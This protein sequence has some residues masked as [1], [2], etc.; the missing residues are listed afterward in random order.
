M[1]LI[2]ANIILEA[3]LQQKKTSEVNEFLTKTNLSDCYITDLSLHSIGI[4]LF[5]EKKYHDFVLFLEDIIIDGFKILILPP[6]QMKNIEKTAR[7]YSLDFDD[8]YQYLAAELNDLQIISFDKDFDKT[9]K[10]R[11]EP[12][13]IKS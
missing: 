13:D 1:Y 5:R 11:K 6:I 2:D 9:E 12:G 3:M 8:A 4:R 7:K 10:G